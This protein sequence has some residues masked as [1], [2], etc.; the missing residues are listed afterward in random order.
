MGHSKKLGTDVAEGSSVR[1]NPK[2]HPRKTNTSTAKSA[3][4]MKMTA[5][6]QSDEPNMNLVGMKKLEWIATR[7]RGNLYNREQSC[8]DERF[9]NESQSIIYEEIIKTKRTNVVQ[10]RQ[11]TFYTFSHSLSL[12]VFMKLVS[13]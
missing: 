3:A 5:S 6:C 2:C 12:M 9:W 13:S 4:K 11:L 7:I 10:K 8:I 1:K